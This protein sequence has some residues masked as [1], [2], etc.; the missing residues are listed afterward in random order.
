MNS[1]RE[2]RHDCQQRIK[3]GI[4]V[5]RYRAER[6]ELEPD[7]S[8]V[9]VLESLYDRPNTTGGIVSLTQASLMNNKFMVSLI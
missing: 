8:Y 5:S 2:L 9:Y 3:S 4:L 7:C 1:V 6:I